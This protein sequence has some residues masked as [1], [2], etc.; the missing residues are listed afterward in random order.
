MDAVPIFIP[1]FRRERV[2]TW[3]SLPPSLQERVVLVVN[4]ECHARL[5]RSPD[6]VGANAVRDFYKRAGVR[7]PRLDLR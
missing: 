3:H 1:T 5:R 2:T 4:A 6:Y 7:V